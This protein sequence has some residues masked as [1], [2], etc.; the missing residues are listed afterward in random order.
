M[1]QR[2]GARRRSLPRVAGLFALLIGTFT[3]CKLDKLLGPSTPPA[4]K[5]LF[6]VQPQNALVNQAMGTAVKVYVA[7]ANGDTVVDAT[8]V[9]TL[10]ITPGSGATGAVLSGTTTATATNGVAI[11][12]TLKVDKA[13]AN[14]TLTASSGTLTPAVSTAFTVI[15]PP[16]ILLTPSSAT[17]SA[18]VGGGNPATQ[19]VGVTNSGSGTLNGLA[20]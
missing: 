2:M 3:T 13:G 19:T 7:D 11:F 16:T 20:V 12:S 8:N 14:Y 17:F 18:V 10:G 9:I 6:Q 1:P 4:T 15:V 5:V